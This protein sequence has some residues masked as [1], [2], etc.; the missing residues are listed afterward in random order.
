MAG[1]RTFGRRVWRF[2]AR[3]AR[4]I[5][6]DASGPARLPGR[7]ARLVFAAAL[8]LATT[9]SAASVY[10]A[11]PGVATAAWLAVGPLLASAVLSARSTAVVAGWTLLLGLGLSLGQ[12]GPLRMAAPHLSVLVL[13]AAFAVANAA[14]LRRGAAAAQPGPGRGPGRAKRAAAR[15]TGHGDRSAAGLTV[16]VSLGRGPGGRRPA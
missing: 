2:A 4:G 7:P 10:V 15:D 5:T 1:V 8:L 13:L 12:P 9:A 14:P 6:L 11:G 16:Y 3:S